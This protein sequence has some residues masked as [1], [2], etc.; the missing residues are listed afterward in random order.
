LQCY[1][2]ALAS[3]CFIVEIVSDGACF[4]LLHHRNIYAQTLSHFEIIESST[5]FCIHIRVSSIYVMFENNS[6]F[7]FCQNLLGR[8]SRTPHSV[9]EWLVIS[10]LCLDSIFRA[11]GVKYLF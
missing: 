9:V 3:I 1:P 4:N 5:S 2:T 6:I 7:I 10:T 11:T 8:R